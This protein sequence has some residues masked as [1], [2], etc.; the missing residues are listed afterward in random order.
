[1]KFK[2]ALAQINPA[3][4]DIEKNIKKHLSF[5]DKAIKK[6]ADLIVFPELSLTGYS[7]KDLNFDIA[8]NP[9]N[10]AVL[11]PLLEKS[12]KI[13]I[14]CGGVEEND[15]FA[16]YNS[17]FYISKG[18]IQ[19]THRKV[20]PPDY[21]MFEEMRYFTRGNSADVPDTK[22]GKIGILVC[23]DLWHMS[24][25]LIQ[26]LKGAKIIITIACSP[27]RLALNSK[28]KILKNYEINSEHHRT[29]ARLLSSYIVFCNRVGFEDGVNFWG[30]S[31][32]IDPFGN[33]DKAAKFFDEDLIISVINLDTVRRA[34]HLARHFMD[35][36]V[37]FLRNEVHL[38]N[39]E[40]AKLK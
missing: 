21:G 24:L 40:L 11:K 12:K 37:N 23:E 32:V 18:R 20:Y 28:S 17:A 35:E 9:V 16:V 1:M 19:Y 38:L 36:D 29:Y 3:L 4:G 13:D 6:G 8:L 39:A 14:I 25:P 5:C 2:I 27:T 34:R 33:V 7:L 30:G 22:F 15:K 26:A 31:E 10:P